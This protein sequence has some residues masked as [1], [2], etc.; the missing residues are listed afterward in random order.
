MTNDGTSLE[1]DLELLRQDITNTYTRA[2]QTAS[3]IV[4][5]AVKEYTKTSDFETFKE[6]MNTMFEQNSEEFIMTFNRLQ[7]RITNVDGDMQA[8]FAEIKK[9]IRFVDGSIVLG[10]ANN[11]IILTIDNDRIS[12]TQNGVEVCYISNTKMGIRE[13]DIIERA[14]IVG[15]N[16]YYASNGSICIN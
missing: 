9:Y 4:M 15:L 3:E 14:A 10:E 1:D 12:F 13:V 5:E 2:T 11:P 6:T 8:E 16:F 7:E